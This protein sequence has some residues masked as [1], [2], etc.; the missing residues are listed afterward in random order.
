MKD[1]DV[2]SL[3]GDESGESTFDCWYLVVVVA[4]GSD[5]GGSDMLFYHEKKG[6]W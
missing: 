3:I 6:S 4:V 1:E 2:H 5:D